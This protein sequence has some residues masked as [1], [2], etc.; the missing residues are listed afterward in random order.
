MSPRWPADRF[1]QNYIARMKIFTLTGFVALSVSAVFIYFSTSAPGLPEQA[2]SIINTSIE[3]GPGEMI[4]GDTGFAKSGSTRLWYESIEPS[5]PKKGTVILIMGIANDALVW[6]DYFIMP[7]L[8]SGYQIIRYDQ[9]DT[10]LSDWTENEDDN[11]YTLEVLAH[12]AVAVLDHLQIEKAHVLGISMGGMVAQSMAIHY[13]ER[14]TSL[15]SMMSSGYIM[16]PDLPDI[17]KQKLVDLFTLRVKYG[18]V[19]NEA[20]MIRLQIGI[21][22]LLK[23]RQLEEASMQHIARYV[24]YNM[25]FR[26]GYN[27]DAPT[28]HI[29]AI[30][31]SGSRY[32]GLKKLAIPALIIHGKRDPLISIKHGMKCANL[33]PNAKSLWVEKM[34]HDIPEDEMEVLSKNILGNFLKGEK[35]FESRLSSFPL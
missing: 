19:E 27:F 11:P 14:I 31:K 1:F 10:G 17:P 34:G 13:P 6:P 30:Y 7:L 3:N 32:E 21:R 5:S 33:I 29:T 18:I 28:R 26:K 16:D 12:D 24:L 2:E 15:T 20:N 35:E 25:R 9:R 22:Q 23:G 8:D 4:K